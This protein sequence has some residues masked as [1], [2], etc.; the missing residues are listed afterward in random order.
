MQDTLDGKQPSHAL[1]RLFLDHAGWHVP[2][3]RDEGGQVALLQLK[4]NAGR[5]YLFLCTD[6]RAYEACLRTV[7]AATLGEH[8][9]TVAGVE[10]FANLPE[11]LDFVRINPWSPPE[12]HYRGDQ[13]PALRQWAR[14]VQIERT[15]ATPCPDLSLIKQFDAFYIVVQ[16]L[17]EGGRALTLAPDKRGRKLAAVFT[18]PDTLEAFLRDRRDG[19]LKFEPLVVKVSGALLFDDLQH[20]PIDGIVFNCAGPVSPR[21]F[22]AQ[23]AKAVMAA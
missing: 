5:R 4:D 3:T 22:V 20:A 13:I 16:Q 14:A 11:T 21:L 17:E 10:L 1:L 8:V 15:L 9:I 7:G 12:L 2:A 19:G 6:R 18:A 23:F